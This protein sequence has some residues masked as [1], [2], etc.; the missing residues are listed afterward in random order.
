MKITSSVLKPFTFLSL[1]FLA[2]CNP[3]VQNEEELYTDDTEE[4]AYWEDE[5]YDYKTSDDFTGNTDAEMLSNGLNC[6]RVYLTVDDYERGNIFV[7]GEKIAMNFDQVE[8]LY[9]DYDQYTVESAYLFT[10]LDGDTVLYY[11]YD[12][13][14]TFSD[15][16]WDEDVD[17]WNSINLVFPLESNQEYYFYSFF[18]DTE[19]GNEIG[20]KIKIEIRE[21]KNIKMANRGIKCSEIHLW[22]IEDDIYVTDGVIE[23]DK[24]YLFGTKN[25]RG[26]KVYD[27]YV[28]VGMSI[29]MYDDDDDQFYY[30]G[31][32][33]EDDSRLLYSEVQD[34]LN[35]EFTVYDTYEFVTIEVRIWDKNG[36]GS[37]TISTTQEMDDYYDYEDLDF[38]Y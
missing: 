18:R 6:D 8:E 35:A 28:N 34:E 25:L 16:A 15:Y 7:Y 14:E 2:A 37:L 13:Q 27:G 30:S 36:S 38:S 33:Y 22:D 23:S 5:E 21:D 29:T 31:D 11:P 19:N 12:Y 32:V 24:N 17:L 4:E 20:G 9:L 1:L 10:E 26:F 3:A